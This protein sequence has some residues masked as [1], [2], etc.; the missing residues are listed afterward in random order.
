MTT[1]TETKKIKW[2]AC[3]PARREGRY[4]GL[5]GEFVAFDRG[6][7]Q[8]PD[9][10]FELRFSGTGTL[11]Q[12]PSLDAMKDAAMK[13]VAGCLATQAAEDTARRAKNEAHQAKQKAERD[14]EAAKLE[15]LRQ[16]RA[17]LFELAEEL[18]HGAPPAPVARLVHEAAE[19]VLELIAST[20]DG[21][22]F[23]CHV[24]RGPQ[25]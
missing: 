9:V 25:P 16:R 2:K 19:L 7:F 17:R 6:H 20:D 13:F 22:C 11:A 12:G 24:G 15:A 4:P 8:K 5:R 23:S 18:N 14:A 10:R 1:K 21:E 3:G